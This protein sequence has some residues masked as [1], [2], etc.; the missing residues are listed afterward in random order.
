MENDLIKAKKVNLKKLRDLKIN[1]YPYSFEISCYAKQVNEE[2]KDLKNEEKSRLSSM[3]GRVI[4]KR[5][6]G[7]IAFMKIRDST[8]DI[9]FFIKKGETPE[10]VFELLELID[11]G[12]IV[13]A[14]GPIYKTQKG[15][16]SIL[17]NEIEMLSKSINIL[18]E[19]YHGLQDIELR[20]RQR[21]LDLIMNP[22]VR[23]IFRLRSKIISVWREFLDLK[24]FLE[25][26]IP[27]LQPTYGGASA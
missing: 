15:Q 9:Q 17:V 4:A 19:K 2:F 1:P 26:E 23:E 16:L 8:G 13:G 6:F 21:Y 5:S 11:V 14:K 10:K 20:Q 12:D 7:A 25:V 3:A 18:P 24:G 22:E 27:V